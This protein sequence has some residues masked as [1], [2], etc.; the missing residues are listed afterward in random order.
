MQFRHEGAATAGESLP[1]GTAANGPPGVANA[2]PEAGG[3]GNVVVNDRIIS[4]AAKN[5]AV[6]AVGDVFRGYGSDEVDT[7]AFVSE[8]PGSAWCS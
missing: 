2:D 7:F 1:P 3:S 8:L 6:A 4:T 5:I